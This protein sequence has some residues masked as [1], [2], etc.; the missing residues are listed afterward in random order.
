MP[1]QPSAADFI[2]IT[3]VCCPAYYAIVGKKGKKARLRNFRQRIKALKSALFQHFVNGLLLV[4]VMTILTF[5]DGGMMCISDDGRFLLRFLRLGIGASSRRRGWRRPPWQRGCRGRS[6]CPRISG[7]LG[8]NNEKNRINQ[9]TPSLLGILLLSLGGDILFLRQ[10]WVDSVK[11]RVMS[12]RP[13]SI[14]K[15][16]KS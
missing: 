15:E 16:E 14:A 1:E 6:R 3:F 4:L 5:Y 9:S 13:S 8:G 11:T 2:M 7:S 12:L 10:E